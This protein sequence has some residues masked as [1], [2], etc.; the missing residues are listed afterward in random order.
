MEKLEKI[1]KYHGIH[2]IK[3]EFLCVHS[4]LNP[5]VKSEIE[6]QNKILLEADIPISNGHIVANLAMFPMWAM[7]GHA[8]P[9]TMEI[10]HTLW[11]KYAPIQ[12]NDKLDCLFVCLFVYV[13]GWG[14]PLY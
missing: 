10:R 2:L 12:F 6:M 5:D 1:Y 9:C 7:L 14:P 11:L 4:K 8:S 3:T 13:V